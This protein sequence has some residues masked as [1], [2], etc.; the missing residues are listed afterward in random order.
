M[1]V[2]PPPLERLVEREIRFELV[3]DVADREVAQVPRLEHGRAVLALQF[4]ERFLCAVARAAFEIVEEVEDLFLRHAFHAAHVRVVEV[5]A[6]EHAAQTIALL[7]D[8]EETV[9][10]HELL[11]RAQPFP[12]GAA[13]GFVLVVRQQHAEAHRTRGH[14]RAVGAGVA[15]LHAPAR[16]RQRT[17]VVRDLFVQLLRRLAL[18]HV[19]FERRQPTVERRRLFG[20]RDLD[21]VV[22]VVP[23]VLPALDEL[24]N[25]LESRR[26][27]EE[28]LP[29][30]VLLHE[31]RARHLGVRQQPHVRPP[32]MRPPWRCGRRS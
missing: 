1:N 19:R 5:L 26:I 6:A 11:D 24:A 12:R 31:V 32:R 2:R 29:R 8:L 3:R 21:V 17:F 13:D 14:E 4:G 25:L 10:E 7:H 9:V 20:G 28:S 27:R 23:S 18:D 22:V 30:V 15:E 16:G